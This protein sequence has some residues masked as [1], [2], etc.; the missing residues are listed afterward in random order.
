M[1]PKEE[2][3]QSLFLTYRMKVL[4]NALSFFKDYHLAEDTAHD[5]LTNAIL[6]IQNSRGGLH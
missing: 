3:F 6:T 4:A 1:S 2:I 5:V